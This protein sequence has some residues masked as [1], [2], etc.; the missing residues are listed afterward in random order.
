MRL[1]FVRGLVWKVSRQSAAAQVGVHGRCSPGRWACSP[2]SW[3][4]RGPLLCVQWRQEASGSRRMCVGDGSQE[5]GR[6]GDTDLSSKTPECRWRHS[7]PQARG[8]AQ[9]SHP[10]GHNV[11]SVPSH[12]SL[13]KRGPSEKSPGGVT[14]RKPWGPDLVL[15]QALLRLRLL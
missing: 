13:S 15:D 2:R 10:V 9:R 4:G 5:A 3:R 14:P 7:G 8:R 11:S 12:L 6:C 1:A